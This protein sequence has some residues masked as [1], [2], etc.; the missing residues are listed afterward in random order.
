MYGNMLNKIKMA[1]ILKI[2]SLIN[3]LYDII[4]DE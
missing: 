2:D 4:L 1:N 3:E